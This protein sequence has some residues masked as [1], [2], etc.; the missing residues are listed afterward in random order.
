VD[1][2]ARP[3]RIVV[4]FMPD[5]STDI[6][7]RAIAQKL[8]EALGQPFVVVNNPGAGGSIGATEVARADTRRR[9]RHPQR[10]DQQG[11]GDACAEVT[12]RQRGCAGSARGARCLRRDDRRRDRA[13]EAGDRAGAHASR[14]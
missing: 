2:P 5:G 9:R 10:R 14:M 8:Q 12:P 13:L 11:P 6:L 3:A 4:P 1:W 7:A